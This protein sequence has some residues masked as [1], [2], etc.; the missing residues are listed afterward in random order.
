MKNLKSPQ[1]QKESLTIGAGEL[2]EQQIKSVN[3]IQY[4][5][6][7]YTYVECKEILDV[8]NKHLQFMAVVVMPE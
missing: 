3:D 2:S 4:L 8:I 1:L 7:G 5:L 6:N